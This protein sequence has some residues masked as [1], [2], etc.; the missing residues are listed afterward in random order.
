MYL[1]LA[2]CYLLTSISQLGCP[3]SVV[4]ITSDLGLIPSR[5]TKGVESGL[6]LVSYAFLFKYKMSNVVDIYDKP[7]AGMTKW[8]H[9]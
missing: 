9:P 7:V 1:G 2:A 8:H 6:T 3:D 5:D 4:D